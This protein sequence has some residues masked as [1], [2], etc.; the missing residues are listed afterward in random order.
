MPMVFVKVNVHDHSVQV[1]KMGSCISGI[2]S[3]IYKEV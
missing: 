2:N 3:N 1:N